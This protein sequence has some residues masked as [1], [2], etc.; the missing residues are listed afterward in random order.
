[1][2]TRW[3][4]LFQRCQQ[5]LSSAAS[6]PAHSDLSDL[7]NAGGNSNNNNNGNYMPVS[8]ARHF[9]S[10]TSRSVSG[11][12]TRTLVY[13]LTLNTVYCTI[14]M[15]MEDI[16]GSRTEQ[17]ISAYFCLSWFDTKQGH[18]FGKTFKSAPIE[19]V[20]G[21]MNPATNDQPHATLNGRNLSINFAETVSYSIY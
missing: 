4:E 5:H 20:I 14:P 21:E 12:K 15:S 2:S 1:M 11:S 13:S 3:F 18:Y 8:L 17:R 19:V 9:R 10:P 6:Y 16:L 7:R